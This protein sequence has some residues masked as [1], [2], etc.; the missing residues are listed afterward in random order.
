M[1]KFVTST[2]LPSTTILLKSNA[3]SARGNGEA[4]E[5]R[6]HIGQRVRQSTCPPAWAPART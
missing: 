5:L 1:Q 2:L 4:D 6:I 3:N